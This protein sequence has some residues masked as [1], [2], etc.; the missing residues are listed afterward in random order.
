[1]AC[2]VL[3]PEPEPELD[4]ELELELEPELELELEL[5]PDRELGTEMPEAGVRCCVVVA[6]ENIDGMSLN[7]L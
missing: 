2:D 1:M 5:E 3:E 7:R 6:A 4:L